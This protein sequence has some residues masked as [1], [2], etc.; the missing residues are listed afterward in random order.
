[1]LLSLF[2]YSH[3]FG[4]SH[5][6]KGGGDVYGDI[7]GY[8]GAG[9]TED[10]GPKNCFNAVKNYRLG[11]Y[12]L[13]LGSTNPLDYTGNQKSFVLNGV[14]DY[15][16]DG[17]SDGELISLR[18]EQFGDDNGVDFYLGYN[19]KAGVNSGV[20]QG[21]DQVILYSKDQGLNSALST[22]IVM[23]D[24]GESYTIDDYRGNGSTVTIKFDKLSNSM[25]DATI[26]LSSTPP[27]PTAAPTISCGGFG[28]FKVEIGIDNFAGETYWQLFEKDTNNLVEEGMD[29][30]DYRPNKSKFEPTDGTAFCL[31]PGS[32]YD[33]KIYDDY[34]DGLKSEQG[35]FYRGFVGAASGGEQ[36][37]KIFEGAEFVSEDNRSFCV[38]DITAGTPTYSPTKA[39]TNDEQNCTDDPDFK[40]QGVKSCAMGWISQDLEKRCNTNA[41]ESLYPNKLIKDYC[42]VTCGSCDSD[43][44][45]PT[46]SPTV[47]IDKGDCTDDPDFKFQGVKSCA[48]GW[49][50]QDLEKRCNKNA[51]ELL[52]PNKLIKD[53]CKVLCN[54]CDP[55]NDNN[56]YDSCAINETP[57]KLE[58]GIDNYGKEISWKI[59]EDSKGVEF[60]SGSKDQ[61]MKQ[62]EYVESYCLPNGASYSFTI[63]DIFGDGLK[64]N[65]NGYYHGYLNNEL[66]F[67]GNTFKN[68]ETTTFT[69]NPNPSSP[70][71][72]CDDDPKFRF[73]KKKKK[74]C[75][76]LGRNKK[77][78]KRR[79]KKTKQ[80]GSKLHKL[81][82][83][84]CG[85]K[86]GIGQCKDLKNN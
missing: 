18:L 69:T 20:S 51:E 35:G 12:D 38:N 4:L 11:W 61:Y 81:C 42:P 30:T 77:K 52:Y 48:M 49:I 79:C 44:S 80:G 5:S 6:G 55:S 40:F 66:Q 63:Y 85:L 7:T 28:R 22:R 39:P 36:Y 82:P 46:T 86:F 73:K 78:G 33:F 53:Y 34:G 8:M 31:D 62:T 57:F 64:P 70:S 45:P 84:T 74:N 54:V 72:F 9:S 17:S 19:R 67:E 25:K 29:K 50:S 58:L 65:E 3:N 23:L 76:W 56:D 47:S 26:T 16:K 59:V 27:P 2:F 13:Q 43:T 15:K 32:C 10:D 60:F 24:I 75:K 37:T 83:Y 14:A 71:N 1:L 21:A 41:K 68:E